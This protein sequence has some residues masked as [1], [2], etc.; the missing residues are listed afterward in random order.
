MLKNDIICRQYY[1]DLGE[2]CHLRVPLPGL[3]L[4]E[5]PQSLLGTAG[6]HP[7]SSELVQEIRQNYFFP[8]IAT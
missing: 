7:D 1:N 6:K 5:L 3:L 2:V 8:S 4:K